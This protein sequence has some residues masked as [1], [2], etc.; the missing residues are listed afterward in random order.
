MMQDLTPPIFDEKLRELTQVVDDSDLEISAVE[1]LGRY[2]SDAYTLSQFEK[3][4]I[5]FIS[6]PQNELSD[7]FV[8]FFA[9]KLLE[10]A[11]EIGDSLS[12]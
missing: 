12:D 1:L 7:D 5:N 10:R 8:M 2:V 11:N 3:D 6:N 4:T 9:R